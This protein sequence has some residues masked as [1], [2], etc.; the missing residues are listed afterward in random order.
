MRK[1][2]LFLAV[3][4]TVT[5]LAACGGDT[6][7]ASSTL[8]SKASSAA[9]SSAPV[10]SEA[11]VND[12]SPAE[13]TMYEVKNDVKV[14]GR[15]A[16][17]GTG[18]TFDNTGNGLLFNA[19]CEG[20][21][22]L[23][24]TVLVN[25]YAASEDFYNCYFTVYVD[26]KLAQQRAKVTGDPSQRVKVDLVLAEGL[27]RGEHTFEVY[28]QSANWLIGITLNTI[29]LSGVLTE[30]PADNA[31][32]IDFV[33]D[34]ITE[35]YGNIWTQDMTV[36]IQSQE[37]EDGM[38]TYATLAARSLG[39]DYSITAAGG[40]TIAESRESY[41]TATK[42]RNQNWGFE[43]KA[44]IVVINLGTNDRSELSNNQMQNAVTAM[45]ELVKQKNPDAK[46]VWAYGLMG[47][48]KSPQIKAALEAAG[49]EAAGYYY[50]SLPYN[51][52]GGGAH[53]SVE[54]HKA[55]AD[56]LTDFIKDIM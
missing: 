46:V 8:S 56:V 14:Q 53:P 12:Y 19:D 1:I 4:M 26:G 41:V 52:A 33:G 16:P 2:S 7:D 42:R 34:S 28:K 23:N 31:V 22:S 24:L 43:R 50:C 32:L 21:V 25:E 44:D 9:S 36:A 11:E 10:S 29:K 49:G 54:G 39:V 47:E 3:L 37:C 55:A 5:C 18:I 15:S 20:T 40:A 27:E 51:G 6:Q 38:Q 35:G 17:D 13:L 30:R 45:I 48:E